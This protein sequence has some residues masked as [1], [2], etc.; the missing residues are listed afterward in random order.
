MLTEEAYHMQT[1]ENGL[2]RIIKRTAE[3]HAAGKDPQTE[4]DPAGDA[5]ALR[6]PLG[7]SVDGPVRW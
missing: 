2:G 6:P 3:L 4:G 1:G 7:I 5:P